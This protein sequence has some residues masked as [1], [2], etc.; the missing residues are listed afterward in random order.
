MK[1]IKISKPAPTHAPRVLASTCLA[2]ALLFAVASN[3]WSAG[4]S[5]PSGIALSR[6]Y[7]NAVDA[8]GV[9]VQ[10]DDFYP[11]AWLKQRGFDTRLSA[12][13]Y[14]WQARRDNVAN[15]SLADLSLTPM[16]RW[17]AGGAAPFYLEA[18][19][20]LRLLTRTQIDDRRLATAAQFGERIGAGFAFGPRS[21]YEAGIYLQHVS[22][23]S[24]KAPNNGLSYYGAIFR[25]PL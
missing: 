20:G 16:L 1:T 10:W 18:G 17:W 4:L 9:E 6:G 23:G 21:R 22:N 24:Y 5:A 25:M 11:S 15:A 13:L 14:Y 3:A 8:T 19:I 2:A 12:G 7:G